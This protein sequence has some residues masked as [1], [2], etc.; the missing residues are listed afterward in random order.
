MRKGEKTN[1]KRVGRKFASALA[2]T[3]A[4]VSTTAMTAF[5]GDYDSYDQP[6]DDYG[7]NYWSETDVQDAIDNNGGSIA[8]DVEIRGTR[9]SSYTV[10][11]PKVIAGNAVNHEID[12]DYDLVVVGDLA[13]DEYLEILPSGTF[14]LSQPGKPDITA[15]V[16]QE[17][18]KFRDNVYTATLAADEIKVNVPGDYTSVTTTGYVQADN[19]SAGLWQGIF[20][21][22]MGIKND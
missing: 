18:K 4:L 12:W 16:V 21:F 15:R 22:R 17:K 3:T 20:E 13:G 7:V 14:T 9:T 2:L 8:T 10:Q 11:L 6:H 1:S 5:A 19:I